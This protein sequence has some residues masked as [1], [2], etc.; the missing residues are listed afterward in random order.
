[1]L[2]RIGQQI[3]IENLN[4][5]WKLLPDL[6]KRTESLLFCASKTRS[7]NEISSETT[8][9]TASWLEY[10]TESLLLRFGARKPR[11]SNGDNVSNS[12]SSSSSW[13]RF[14]VEEK[15]SNPFV[16]SW[17][18]SASSKVVKKARG[19]NQKSLTSFSSSR[20]NGFP[21]KKNGLLFLRFPGDIF[22]FGDIFFLTLYLK[23]KKN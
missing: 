6:K 13:R 2:I 15:V 16:L 9:T 18:S 3:A 10:R 19:K 23:N 20:V 22:S 7:P 11:S 1:M 5:F 14:R 21:E 8:L 4:Q 12:S 17:L